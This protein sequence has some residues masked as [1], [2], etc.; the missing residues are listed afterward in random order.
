MK[1]E[2]QAEHDK[3]V[4]EVLRRLE[5][6]D[7]FMKPEKYMFCATEVD[8]LSM[9]VKRD[10]IKMDQEK[11]KAILAWPELK[12][13]KGVR[14][15]LRLVNFYQ[16]FIRDY[17]KVARPLHDFTK[18]ENPF[19]W[20]EP[21]Q[22][23]FDMLKLHFTMAPILAFPD[24]D[25]VFHLESNTSNYTTGTALSIEKEGVWH[26]V[27]FSSHSMMPQEWNYPI[28]DK[29]ML[30]A[31]QALKQ[32]HH[33][34]EGARHQFEITYRRPHPWQ[35]LLWVY[36]LIHFFDVDVFY[37]FNVASSMSSYRMLSH[38]QSV[39]TVKPWYLTLFKVLSIQ[40]SEVSVCLFAYQHSLLIFFF[41]HLHILLYEHIFLGCRLALVPSG[42]AECMLLLF[43]CDSECVCHCQLWTQPAVIPLLRLTNVQSRYVMIHPHGLV[44]PNIVSASYLMSSVCEQALQFEAPDCPPLSHLCSKFLHLCQSFIA[45]SVNMP[46]CHPPV[47]TQVIMKACHDLV[48]QDFRVRLVSCLHWEIN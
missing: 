12:T 44:A 5:E 28:T 26:P 3:I 46:L 15:F 21:Q 45:P 40:L 25:C 4:L 42:C 30:S 14:S 7:L 9:I 20:E 22:V 18:K 48:L 32:W 43:I 11:V 47:M 17:V 16:R 39:P 2:N 13:V 1:T 38:H 31:I 33:Y 41:C 6:N 23:A 8:F 34:L 24:I 35:C 10:G 19:H 36:S 37:T 29:E 27:A